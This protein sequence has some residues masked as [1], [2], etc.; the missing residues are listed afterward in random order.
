MAGV[1]DRMI[2]RWEIFINI[3]STE[4][5]CVLNSCF[6]LIFVICNGDDDECHEVSSN[7]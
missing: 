4:T 3:Y 1:F 2:A 7:S 6:F 5:L